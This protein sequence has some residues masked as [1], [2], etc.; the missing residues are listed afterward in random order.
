[1][2]IA[3][4]AT[5]QDTQML[6]RQETY[7]IIG[8]IMEELKEQIARVIWADGAGDESGFETLNP[9]HIIFKIAGKTLTLFQNWLKKEN[10]VQLEDILAELNGLKSTT[11]LVFAIEVAEWIAKKERDFKKV[12]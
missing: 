5:G 10:Y 8:G 11:S 2:E 6:N 9:T 4:T 12:L 3:K 7:D 1:M